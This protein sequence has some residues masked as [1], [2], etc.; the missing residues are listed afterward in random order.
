MMQGLAR[1]LITAGAAAGAMAAGA[2]APARANDARF[3]W[4]DYAGLAA[5]P[6]PAAG[7]YRNPIIA[8]Y[9]PDPSV[10]RVGPDFYLVNSTFSWFPGIPIW[11]SRD[12][13]HWRQIGNAIDQP[14]QLDFTKLRISEGVFAPAISYHQGRYYIV[15]TCIACGGNYVIT[16]TRPEGPWTKPVWLKNVGGIDPSLF[17]DDDGSAWLTNNDLPEGGERYTG[18]RA[19]WLRR[20]DLRTLQAPGRGQ[21][22][23]EGSNAAKNPIWIEGPHLFKKDGRYYL[24]AAEGGTDE[25]HSEVILRSERIHG[26]YVPAPTSINPILTQRDLPAERADPVTSTGHAELVRL[27]DD[28]WWAVFLG[29]RPY[30]PNLYNTGRETFLLPVEWRDGWPVILPHGAPVPLVAKAPPLPLSSAAPTTGSFIIHEDF[31]KPRLDPAWMMMRTPDQRWWRTGAGGLLL[32]ARPERIGDG[33]QPSFLGHRQQH[34]DA[35]VTTRVTFAPAPGDEAGLAAVQND[36]YF[37]SIALVREGGHTI[38]RAARRAGVKEPVTGT[39]LAV[40]AAPAGPVE[41]R[42]HA[43]GPR[44]DFAYRTPNGA[45]QVLAAGV[46]GTNLSSATAGGFVGTLI[47]PYAQTSRGAQARPAPEEP[48]HLNGAVDG[49]Q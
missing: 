8:G 36:N 26:R 1:I 5:G 43:R 29:T 37:L 47:G 15:N 40:R 30:A 17:F 4:V 22:I 13:V 18:H 2:G 38:V 10:L 34:A 27:A 25:N 24:V 31:R 33:K 20:F 39:I 3:E 7:Q 32:Q 42:I 14:G 9:Y 6:E 19:I 46:D 44:Y 28:R 45:W 21:V 48:Y 35:T 12:L 23:A 49:S 11:H 16:A 41:L